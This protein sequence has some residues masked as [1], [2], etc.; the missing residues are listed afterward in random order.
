MVKIDK[1]YYN[2]NTFNTVEEI[3]PTTLINGNKIKVINYYYTNYIT[4]KKGKEVGYKCGYNQCKQYDDNTYFNIHY[5]SLFLND[6]KNST[7][8]YEISYKT[9]INLP[10]IPTGLYTSK[11][12]T[13]SGKY[14]G[15]NG[16]ITL[17]VNDGFIR[18]ITIKYD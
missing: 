2:K 13:G 8:R 3:V 18:K 11:I 16:L 12:I 14:E 5:S 1:F 7:I 4:N 6:C 10:Y 17:D 9:N 15:I